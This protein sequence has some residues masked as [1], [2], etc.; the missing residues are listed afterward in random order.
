MKEEISITSIYKIEEGNLG[1]LEPFTEKYE[2]SH[3]NL[4]S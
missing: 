2:F 1:R 4:V 3:S